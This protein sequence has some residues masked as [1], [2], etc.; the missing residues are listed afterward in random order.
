MVESDGNEG[1]EHDE[2][3]G[4]DVATIE[5]PPPPPPPEERGGNDVIDVVRSICE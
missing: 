3:R 2:T 1:N 5:L 4:N